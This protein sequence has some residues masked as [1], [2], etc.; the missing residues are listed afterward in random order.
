MFHAKM[1]YGELM[2]L[3]IEQV[4]NLLGDKCRLS[5]LNLLLDGRPMNAKTLSVLTQTSP[6]AISNHLKRL[7]EVGWL[8]MQIS[9]RNHYFF[10]AN[11]DVAY[12]IEQFQR[13][14]EKKIIN[15]EE[16]PALHIA[17]SCYDHLAGVISIRFMQMLLKNDYIE[18]QS[19][20]QSMDLTAA[21]MVF[22]E[23]LGINIQELKNQK[24]EFIL[25]CQDWSERLPH[26]SGALGAALLKE[27]IKN[28]W[29]LHGKSTR[30]LTLTELG[31]QNL[32]KCGINTHSK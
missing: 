1:N 12:V 24:R 20:A 9:G 16:K 26:L 14:I 3:T 8:D 19:P 17:R 31:R 28:R 32:S 29:F 27:M 2:A 30:A 10:L 25:S 22:F 15:P 6:Q 4:S 11:A 23:R 5:I 21:G 18:M 7:L 13:L